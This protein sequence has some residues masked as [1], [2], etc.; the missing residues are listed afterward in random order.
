MPMH[1]IIPT[2]KFGRKLTNVTLCIPYAVSN[3]TNS[4][5]Y[6]SVFIYIFIINIKYLRNSNKNT[7]M[8]RKWRAME[9]DSMKTLK[10]SK[11]QIRPKVFYIKLFCTFQKTFDKT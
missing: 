3:V 8:G 11:V 7:F 5:K 9:Y 1:C 10:L 4:L 2:I 6:A